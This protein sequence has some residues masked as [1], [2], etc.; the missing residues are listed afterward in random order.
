MSHCPPREV[1][2]EEVRRKIAEDHERR[3]RNLS[4]VTEKPGAEEGTHEE[5]G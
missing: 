2:E 4:A 5:R 3:C 1:A